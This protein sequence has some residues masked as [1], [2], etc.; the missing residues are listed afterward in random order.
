MKMVETAKNITESA[1]P[2]LKR[3]CSKDSTKIWIEVM[4]ERS[5]GPPRV[6]P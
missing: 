6:V 3:N 4:S 2:R 5:A 1:L